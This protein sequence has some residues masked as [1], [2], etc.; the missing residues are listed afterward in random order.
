MS[1]IAVLE[2]GNILN[3]LLRQVSISEAELAW[4][5][6]LP[7]T[8]ISRL[9][10][11]RTP[12]LRAST[13]SA[14]AHYFNVSVDQLLGKQPLYFDSNQSIVAARYTSIP[15]IDLKE[16][17]NWGELISKLKPDEHFDWI[18]VDPSIEEGKFALRIKGESM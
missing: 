12:D 4:K 11:G 8:T 6:N 16:A 3:Y 10:S 9:A 5:I 14:I 1:T 2:I 15:D 18:M 17:K 13:L 7:R